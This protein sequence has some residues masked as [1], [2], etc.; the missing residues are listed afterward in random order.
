MGPDSSMARRECGEILPIVQRRNIALI[1]CGLRQTQSL[2]V[3][4]HIV[5]AMIYSSTEHAANVTARS[6]AH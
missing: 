2:V 1:R 4:S 6:T 3:F 5:P